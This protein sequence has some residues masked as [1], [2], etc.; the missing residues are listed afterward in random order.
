MHVLQLGPYPP[1]EGGINRNILAIREELRRA[2]HRCSIV[3]TSRSSRIEPEPD[4]YHPKSAAALLKLL[5][6]LKYDL[7][8]LHIGGDVTARVLLLVAACGLIGRGKNVFSLHSGGYPLT[9]AG[10]SAGPSSFRGW[11]FRRFERLIAVNPSIAEVFERYGIERD[12]IHEITPFIPQLP[13]SSVTVPDHLER[14]ASQHSPFILTVGLLEPEYDLEF[15]I[16]ALGEV[17]AEHPRAGLMLIGEGSLHSRLK[18]AIEGREYKDSIC[19]T[20]NVD[21][22]VTLHL[23][24][25]ADMLLRTTLFDGDAISVREAL[26]L[27]TPVIATD[28]GMRPAGIRL[29]DAGDKAGLLTAITETVG[30]GAKI[31]RATPPNQDGRANILAIIDVYD[32]IIGSRLNHRRPAESKPQISKA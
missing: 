31:D 29:I 27:G 21:H 16:N 13:D 9:K 24:A 18:A 2:G 17:L 7:L 20:G 3:A 30:M 32:Q 8:H 26:F 19:L 11:L 23:I 5:L 4:V 28:N 10:R 22:P 12:R 14:F 6:T 25:R 15:Q 1:P